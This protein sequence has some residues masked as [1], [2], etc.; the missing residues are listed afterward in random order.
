MFFSSLWLGGSLTTV[1][2][3]KIRI[4]KYETEDSRAFVEDY[5]TPRATLSHDAFGATF[6][7]YRYQSLTWS[8]RFIQ[9]CMVSNLGREHLS[10]GK[11]ELYS[12]SS[13]ES[14]PK[15][16]TANYALEP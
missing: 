15:Y 2:F 14:P 9:L 7:W 12:Q 5:F 16:E 11:Y 8:K 10:F 3:E 1:P 13:A 6:L 4:S